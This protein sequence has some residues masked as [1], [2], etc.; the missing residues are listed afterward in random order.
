MAKMFG[1]AKRGGKPNYSIIN[2]EM[3][4]DGPP[5]YEG[6]EHVRYKDP[7]HSPHEIEEP[8]DEPH[9][10][11]RVSRDEEHE[12]E[13]NYHMGIPKQ[14]KRSL[15]HDIK[16]ARMKMDAPN[17][18]SPKALLGNL[19]T[20]IPLRG[21]EDT[22]GEK[23]EGPNEMQEDTNPKEHRKKMIVAVMKRKIKKGSRSPGSPTVNHTS[24][25]SY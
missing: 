24:N 15:P 8:E 4:K 9:M 18:Q 25:P 6:K 5:D 7:G 23:M 22:S 12:M 17:Q 19:T 21:V 2:D 1:Y 16:R 3:D 13:D 20:S 10:K 11:S 14:T